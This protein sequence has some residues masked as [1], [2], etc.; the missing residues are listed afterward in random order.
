MTQTQQETQSAQRLDPIASAPPAVGG[1]V[2]HD[3]MTTDLRRAVDY[4]T[5]LL[6]WTAHV[7]EIGAG[8][9]YTMIRAGST[10]IGGV[11]RLDPALGIASH[12]IGYATVDDVDATCER[13]VSLGG[14][15]CVAATD[16]PNAG[17]FAVLADPDGAIVSPFRSV[18]G[19]VPEATATGGAGTFCWNELLTRNPDAV[20]GFYEGVF[21]WSCHTADMGPRGTYWL[22]RRGDADAAGMIRM[23][24]DAD[25]RPFWMP[26]VAVDDVDASARRAAGLGGEI[27]VAPADIP[28][29]GR[30]AVTG[31]PTGATLA[32]FRATGG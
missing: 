24:V 28:G 29:V 8:E 10:D 31:D 2:W 20:T 19:V 15:V 9:S 11:V 32:L 23:P 5:R 27:F 7:V 22:F 21:G 1:F 30:Y 13:A 3:L 4:H 18:Q 26:Y 16:I 14:R 25:A 6:G 12:W 17:R